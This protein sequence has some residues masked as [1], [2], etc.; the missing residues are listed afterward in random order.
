MN[1]AQV[2]GCGRLASAAMLHTERRE[3]KLHEKHQDY[4]EVV[5]TA[6]RW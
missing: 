5:N 3:P 2:V 6:R 4:L 1:T